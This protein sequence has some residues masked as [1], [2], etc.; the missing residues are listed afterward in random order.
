MKAAC[1]PSLRL[2]LTAAAIFIGLVVQA[3]CDV[4]AGADTMFCQQQGQLFATPDSPGTY[5]FSW[6]PATGLDNANA[7]NPNVI[8]G[9]HNQQYIVTMTDLVN[10]CTAMDTV[11]VSAYYFSGG[12]TTFICQNS[13]V[14]LDFGPGA[15]NYFWQFYTD[16]SG[17]T[18]NLNAS[19]QTLTVTQPGTYS[20]IAFFTGCGALTNVFR[21]V[22]NCFSC[23]VNAGPDTMFCQQ[24]G[25]LFATPAS[26]GNYTFVWSPATGLDD[27]N[28]QNPNVISGV[29][30]QQY[31]VTMTDPA[32]NCTA[33]DT[34]VVS[35]YYFSGG[36]TTFICQSSPVVL[37]FGPGASN[38][39][40][41]FYAD[42]AGNTTMINYSTQ[43]L[44]V[45][46]PGAY[47]GYAMF[48]GCGALTSVFNVVENCNTCA[49][50]AGPDTMFCQ[51]Q[52]QLTATPGM[53]G[54]YTYSWSPSVGLDNPNTQNPNVISGVH[55]QQ[56]I[57]TMTDTATNCTAYDTVVVSAYYF[58]IDTVYLC[59][60]NS[61]TYDLG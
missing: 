48:P 42:T 31:I 11:I 61:V 52:G 1:F 30:N 12:D 17:N 16:T 37:D 26:P 10:S 60:G 57:V 40:W 22:E 29:H 21:V 32:N 5:S 23:G 19:T 44:T 53:P 4:D 25:Q 55:N 9:V 34:V 14:T 49:V 56:Y 33:Y 18:T 15:S 51:Q 8:S 47:M 54:N 38:Y 28:A 41:Q 59:N 43:T 35:A 50:S 7:Q 24:Q 3:Q 2:T 36:D 6:S 39:F 20:G 13:P 46:Q 45:T 27:A 58:H